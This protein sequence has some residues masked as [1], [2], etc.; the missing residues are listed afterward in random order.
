MQLLAL[1][2]GDVSAAGFD[3]NVQTAL[4][5]I[6]NWLDGK[7]AVPI[8]N[9]MEDAATAEIARSQLWQWRRYST[10]LSTAARPM[11]GFPQ[12]IASRHGQCGG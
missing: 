8:F 2:A 12:K 3:N 10:R 9:I 6:A 11:S 5:Y 4:I 1:P 7:G